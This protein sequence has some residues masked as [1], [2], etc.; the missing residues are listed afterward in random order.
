MQKCDVASVGLPAFSF[1]ISMVNALLFFL[2][3]SNW[4]KQLQDCVTLTISFPSPN[5][6]WN[7]KQLVIGSKIISL[8]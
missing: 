3:P 1:D 4:Q 2:M 7:Q 5:S 6:K 8:Q